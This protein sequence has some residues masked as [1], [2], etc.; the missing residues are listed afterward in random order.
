M[1]VLKE[2]TKEDIPYFLKNLKDIDIRFLIQLG[3]T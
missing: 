3:V 1:P 2:F